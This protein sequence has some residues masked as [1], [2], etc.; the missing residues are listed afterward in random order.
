[1]P[2]WVTTFT[3]V[4]GTRL[5][6]IRAI[7]VFAVIQESL[8]LVFI[9]SVVD[10]FVSSAAL[11]HAGAAAR[12]RPTTTLALNLVTRC[13]RCI[14]VS[15]GCGSVVRAASTRPITRVRSEPR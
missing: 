9:D 12:A 13:I 8:A 15:S 7:L 4:P 3:D 2:F 14:A 6:A 1:M 11:T 10:F 5:S